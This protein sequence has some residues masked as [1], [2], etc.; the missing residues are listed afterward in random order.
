MVYT[1]LTY[2]R[3]IR[4]ST[5]ILWHGIHVAFFFS[6][7]C[8]TMLFL[9]LWKGYCVYVDIWECLRV[10]T[11]PCWA[12]AVILQGLFFT[13]KTCTNIWVVTMDWVRLILLLGHKVDFMSLKFFLARLLICVWLSSSPIMLSLSSLICLSIS[14]EFCVIT[15]LFQQWIYNWIILI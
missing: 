6:L 15:F 14:W 8:D 10:N 1:E 11:M 5:F 13:C 3:E 7:V 9:H 4:K 12:T 2:G